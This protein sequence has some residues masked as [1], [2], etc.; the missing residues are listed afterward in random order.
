MWETVGDETVGML[1]V[2]P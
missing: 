1:V 2:P